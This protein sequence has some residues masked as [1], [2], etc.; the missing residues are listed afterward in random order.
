V[1]AGG[2]PGVPGPG[3]VSGAGVPGCRGAGLPGCPTARVELEPLA[4]G[5]AWIHALLPAEDTAAL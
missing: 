5:M 4:D 1:L 3:P 2:A